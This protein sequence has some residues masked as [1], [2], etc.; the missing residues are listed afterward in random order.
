MIRHESAFNWR[1]LF[2]DRIMQVEKAIDQLKRLPAMCME[3]L[4]TF[5]RELTDKLV[6]SKCAN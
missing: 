3:K 5:G 2:K 4:V 6:N 1:R